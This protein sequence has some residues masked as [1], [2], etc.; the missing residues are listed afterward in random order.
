MAEIY[1]RLK[2]RR[3]FCSGKARAAQLAFRPP[4]AR[5]GFS[6]PTTRERAI[7]AQKPREIERTSI[8]IAVQ[9]GGAV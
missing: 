7:L 8:Y 4:L 6:L 1:G 3:V 9:I 2:R 5:V